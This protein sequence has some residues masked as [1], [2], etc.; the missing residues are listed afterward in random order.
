MGLSWRRR[1]P[2]LPAASSV[3]PFGD[4]APAVRI[5]RSAV[6]RSRSLVIVAGD[7]RRRSGSARLGSYLRLP[8][9]TSSAATSRSAPQARGE[10]P[11]CRLPRHVLSAD[12]NSA[13]IRA[14]GS[15][16][17][18][19]VAGRVRRRGS[20]G[21]CRADHVGPRLQQP[22]QA[23][24]LAGLR[25]WREDHVDQHFPAQPSSTSSTSRP[26]ICLASTNLLGAFNRS[27][28]AHLGHAVVI[29]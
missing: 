16:A 7:V 23:R 9:Q 1:E 15:W 2:G 13:G 28:A 19:Q 26:P 27:G 29:S 3:L 12:L 8:F 11:V 20:A 24:R 10:G 6:R 21:A 4:A 14:A 5:G 22:F 25:A 18:P 17:H